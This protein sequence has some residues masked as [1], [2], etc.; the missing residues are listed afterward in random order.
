MLNLRSISK[1]FAISLHRKILPNELQNFK[2]KPKNIR[3]FFIGATTP[4]YDLET[5]I[6][7]TFPYFIESLIHDCETIFGEI[8]QVPPIFSKKDGVR[9]YEHARAGESIEI[10]S[11]KPPFNTN[12]KLPELFPEIDF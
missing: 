6:D 2:V 12:L 4:S 9:L 7:Q 8:D 1:W 5:E 10:V 11:R 3:N